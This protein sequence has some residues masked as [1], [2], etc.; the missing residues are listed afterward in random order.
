MVNQSKAIQV[1]CPA[2]VAVIGASDNPNK[3][4]GRPI[5]YMRKFGYGGRI[6]P[7]NPQRQ[8]V[9]GIDCYASLDD[10]DIVPETAIIAVAGEDAVKAVHDCAR[11]GVS[12]AILMAS[13]F[14][15]TGAAGL[16]VQ[17]ELVAF[18]LA[19][20]MRLVGPNAQGL[21]NFATGAVLNFSTMFM[22][23]PPK[24]G[25][26]A[27][28]SQSGA[29]SVMPY[30]LLREKGLGVRYLAAT[31][32]DAD[33]G[34]SE[35][36][37]LIAADADIR[38]ILV[39]VE[40]LTRPEFL[41]EAADLARQHG[42]HIVLLKGG[43]SLKGAVAA[44]SHT[45]AIVGQDAA[46][47]AF[48][49]QN[50]I[51]RAHDIHELVNAAPL[52]LSGFSPKSGRTVVM[53]HS[54]AVGVLCADAAER[55]GLPLA[56][57][58][59]TTCNS[60]RSL[61]PNFATVANPLDLTAALLGDKEMFPR[62]LD[63]LGD[64]READMFLFG[65]PVAGPGYDV[66]AL[67]SA[68]AAFASH[69]RKPVA[70]TAPQ[71][72][73]RRQFQHCGIPTFTGETDAVRALNQYFQ[74]CHFHRR[75]TQEPPSRIATT[76]AHGL[77][78]EADSLAALASFGLPVVDHMVCGDADSAVHAASQLND[79]VVIKGCSADVPHKTEHGLVH[80]N[81][82][83]AEEVRTAA[84]DCLAKLR[85]LG[86]A[87]PRVLVARMLKGKHEFMLGATVDPIFG[88]V[89]T[90]GEG[91][92]LVELRHDVVSLLPPFHEEEVLRA[93][94]RLRVAPILSGFRGEP[95]LD[96]QALAKAAVALGHFALQHRATLHAVDINPIMVM[97]SG[98]GAIAV[99][100]VV[101][102]KDKA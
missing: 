59:S 32:N 70:V 91:G 28:V 99:D 22:E 42:A 83:G 12:T 98:Q 66:P 21:A 2:S 40:S 53:S 29:A 34:V 48:L 47:D 75:E 8:S 20:G 76:L 7:I 68:T 84:N 16:L 64:S 102:F 100:A 11:R 55:I 62:V 25:P 15:E 46:L 36:V 86:A 97:P 27:V 78:D 77:L 57:L 92:T 56:E 67:A 31:G 43:S 61:L 85:K 65:I 60:L 35:L 96:A 3:V 88:P 37:R 82:L 26:I 17:R 33:L 101:E 54:G 90:I 6:L 41:A 87:K 30:A 73:V 19:H 23:V 69:N 24:D 79:S 13:G 95:A 89:I 71:E 94:K 93:I 81:V 14:A 5:H 4:G 49:E 72:S 10:T 39:Y 50:G 58:E 45:G 38:L 44:A 9:Q 63:V 74:Q 52:Y 18:A 1:L 51:W 80:I